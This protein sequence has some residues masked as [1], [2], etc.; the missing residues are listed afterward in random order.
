[1]KKLLNEQN[2][3][4]LAN[5]IVIVLFGT[6]FY[7]GLGVTGIDED[8]RIIE[9]IYLRP[10]SIHVNLLKI[11]LAVLVLYF[12][13]KISKYMKE[14]KVRNIVL[15]VV[16]LLAGIISVYWVY[17]CK[18]VPQADQ[19]ILCQ[20]ADA[21]NMGDF[22]GF[23]KGIYVARYPQQIGI[24]TLLR[25]L[26]S[27]FG[28]GN[29]QAFQY[30]SAMLVPVL[31]FAGCNIVRILS[32]DNPR[33]ELYYL[34]FMVSCFPMYTYTTFVYGDLVSI[35]FAMLAV[36]MFLSCI[37]KFAWYKAILFGLLIG[38][39]VQLRTNLLIL[40]I[41]LAIVML[42][43]LFFSR[44]RQNIVLFLALLIGVSLSYGCM[45]WVYR[46]VRHEDAPAIPAILFVVMGLNDDYQKPGWHNNYEYIIFAECNDDVDAATQRAISDLK[47]YRELFSTNREYMLDF[48][49]RKMNTQWNAP[50]Y[51]AITMN[52]LVEGEQSAI[53]EKIYNGGRLSEAILSMMKVFQLLM[54]GSILFWLIVR[55]KQIKNIEFYVLLIA[56]FGG[57]LFSMMWEA[58]TRYILP[59][60]FMQIP[61]MA[62]GVDAMVGL[63]KSKFTPQ[64]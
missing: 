23:K 37:Q 26:F 57:F 45:S 20:Y 62:L 5:F 22:S 36:W 39:A 16:C 46:D 40:V 63:L 53:I 29:Y 49:T 3:C 28:T 61:Y 55:R 24:I 4:Y 38:I 10:D 12:A 58:K 42:V 14:R 9:R 13:G 44:N 18:S 48:Y 41:A 1:M 27:L 25:I 11:F 7:Y 19:M 31:I 33:V 47:M 34:L 56:V 2:I 30:L 60:L 21:F 50:M 52:S 35:V 59:Y 51:Q 43:K 17:G 8:F 6:L 15:A 54:Y 32:N 64:K